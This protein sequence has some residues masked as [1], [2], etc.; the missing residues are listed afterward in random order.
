MKKFL[1]YA[2]VLATIV[3]SS[4][5][6][7]NPPVNQTTHNSKWKIVDITVPERS[8]E[9]FVD[10]DGLNA[11]YMAS[12]DVPELTQTVFSDGLVQCYL[13]DGSAQMVLPYTRHYEDVN[14]AR[15][16]TTYDYEYAVG[17]VNFFITDN[18]F[19]G[20]YPAGGMKFRLV[21]LW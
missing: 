2:V 18:D 12:V 13:V 17:L 8:W 10:A 9:R 5:G 20:G 19:A 21:L 14:G 15:W 7:N 1:F 11:Y 4:C 6:N 3:L 16:T